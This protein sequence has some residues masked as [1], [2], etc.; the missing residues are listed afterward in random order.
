[1]RARGKEWF[2]IEISEAAYKK[3]LNAPFFFLG[4]LSQFADQSFDMIYSTEVLEHIPEPEV[5]EVISQL[6]RVA[7]YAFMTISLRPSS[8]NNRYHC[9][10]R[11][12]DWWE[13]Q[14]VARGFEV[15]H[16]VVSGFQRKSLKSTRRI[17]R[18]WAGL[19]PFPKAFSENPPY[20]LNGET[21]FWYFAFR[22]PGER[23]SWLQ[24]LRLAS[25]RQWMVPL[26]RSMLRAS[27]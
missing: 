9:T 6:C 17:L 20:E 4:D 19:G 18:R 27:G 8:D 16:D 24:R 21:Q 11:P 3:H 22:R 13:G 2:G 10:L 15:D 14:F 12:R 7:R 1:M 26:L 23:R 25:H 5:L